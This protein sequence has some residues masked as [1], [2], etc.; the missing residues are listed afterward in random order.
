MPTARAA[1]ATTRQRKLGERLR[2]QRERFVAQVAEPISRLAPPYAAMPRELLEQIVGDYLDALADAVEC[3]QGETFERFLDGLEVLWPESSLGVADIIRGVQVLGAACRAL[4]GIDAD[5]LETWLQESEARIASRAVDSLNRRLAEGLAR[6]QANEERLLALQRVSTA[7]QSELELESVL[8][9]I[10]E[11]AK[12]LMG[13]RAATIRLLDEE[14]GSLRVLARSGPSEQTAYSEQMPI[15]GSLSGL[16]CRIGQPII[17]NDVQRDPRL[18]A[19]LR[20]VTAQRSLLIVP[21]LVRDRPIGVVLVSDREGGFG[22]EDERLLTLFA[23]QAV[24]AIDHARLYQQAQRRIADLDALQR[25]SRVISSSLD[26]DEVFVSIYQ[27]ISRL[28]PADGLLISLCREDALVDIEFI[29]DGGARYPRRP[30][31]PIST[32]MREVLDTRRPAVIGDIQADG[33]PDFSTVGN[34]QPLVRSVVVAPMVHGEEAVGMLSAQ[35]YRPH[36]YSQADAQLLM[37]IA[38]H[39]VVA[40]DH[41]RLFAQAQQVAVVEERNRLARE[42]HD[43][44]AQGLIGISLY[45][46]RLDLALLPGDDANRDLVRRALAL[47]QSNLVEAR[48]S[49]QNLRAASLEGHTLLEALGRLAREA[50]DDGPECSVSGPLSLPPLPA[51]VEAALFRVA[52]EALTNSRKH[53]RCSRISIRL[54]VSGDTV[55]LSIHDD[56]QGFAVERALVRSGRFGL[57]SMRE[58]VEQL[59]GEFRLTSASG[60]GTTV[61]CRLPL[62]SA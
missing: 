61:E 30:A 26:L 32:L 44:L 7:V 57:H 38:N 12:R 55:S 11:E 60:A 33:M 14:T 46:E 58:R 36:D 43:T 20:R 42:I 39:A 23:A 52:Q 49:V 3:G 27:E 5:L 41:A 9:L 25:L 37:T 50:G 15:E 48:R 45:L 24:V 56:G 13:A 16:C 47:T 51:D 31:H 40:I 2:A 53:A 17:S 8:T 10:A 19:E 54:A 4:A 28:M 35:S 18:A 22:A 21:L 6:H 62:G 59:G 1:E 29:V 34:P